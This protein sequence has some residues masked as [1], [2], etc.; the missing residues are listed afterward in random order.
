[1]ADGETTATRRGLVALL[2]ADAGVAALVAGRVVDEPGD[3]IALPYV[4]IGRIETDPDDT[5]GRLGYSVTA[6]LEVHSRPEAGHVEAERVLEA[7]RRALHRRP[8][9]ITVAGFIVTEIEAL[10]G[11][12][13][14]AG[15]GRTYAGA[16]AVELT[17]DVA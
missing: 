16:L 4:R 15:D 7:V 10:A 14:R 1:M 12:V 3:G 8:A 13:D 17:L 9:A 2:T 11:G 6:G 5:D